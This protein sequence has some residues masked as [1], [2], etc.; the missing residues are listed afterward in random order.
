MTKLPESVHEP[1]EN[2]RLVE[3]NMGP[4]L[5]L[6]NRFLGHFENNCGQWERKLI[7]QIP[8]RL[9]CFHIEILATL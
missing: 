3:I 7:C 9:A 8:S 2:L 6:K 5:V 1:S 4:K